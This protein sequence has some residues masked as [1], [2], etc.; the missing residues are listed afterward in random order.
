MRPVTKHLTKHAKDLAFFPKQSGSFPEL[1]L[2]ITAMSSV[3]AFLD[4]HHLPIYL[5]F[6]NTVI[7]LGRLR[8]AVDSVLSRLSE[9]TILGLPLR[10]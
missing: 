4:T 6:A 9:Y 5:F 8:L 3:A 2:F 1:V 10:R 7:H